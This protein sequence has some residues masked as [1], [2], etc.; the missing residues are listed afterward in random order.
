MANVIVLLEMIETNGCMR[1]KIPHDD[2]N[3]NSIITNITV[4][5]PF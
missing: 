4:F 1:C 5:L 2:D 3:D